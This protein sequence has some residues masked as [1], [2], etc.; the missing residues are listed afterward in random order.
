MVCIVL[1]DNVHAFVKFTYGIF[2]HHVEIARHCG[3][4][5]LIGGFR[6]F[7]TIN[8]VELFVT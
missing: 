1:V 6:H 5:F 8:G 2:P 3:T 7:S 4:R